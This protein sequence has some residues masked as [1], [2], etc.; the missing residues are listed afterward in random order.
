MRT[1]YLPV[2]GRPGEAPLQPQRLW[3]LLAEGP[4]IVLRMH[5]VGHIPDEEMNGAD[6]STQIV[7]PIG[8]DTI[9]VISQETRRSMLPFR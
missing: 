1:K 3:N 6:L 8:R 2:N 4:L 9:K 7:Q 5:L